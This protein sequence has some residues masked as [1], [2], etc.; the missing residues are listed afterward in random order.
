MLV[1]HGSG[2]PDGEMEGQTP[3]TPAIRALQYIAL[4][5]T[6]CLDIISSI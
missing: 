3:S 5:M 4:N 6:L 1:I 2:G